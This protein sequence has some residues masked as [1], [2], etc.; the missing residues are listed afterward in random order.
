MKNIKITLSLLIL[1]SLSSCDDFLSEIPDN[2]TL[3]DTPEKISE[4][5]VTAYPN[6]TY[7]VFAE[8]MSDNVFDSQ[9][10][11]SNIDN[12]QSFNWEMQSQFGI[13]TEAD[14]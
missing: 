10:Q 8:T 6:R 5:L 7:M 9:M 3:I 13:D 11:D 2:R 12:R 1:I 4:L 14:F